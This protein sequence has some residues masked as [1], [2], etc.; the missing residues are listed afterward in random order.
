MSEITDKTKEILPDIIHEIFFAKEKCAVCGN[1]Y[2]SL[3]LEHP[4]F[5]DAHK[6]FVE[7][8]KL[9]QQE[10][11]KNRKSWDQLTDPLERFLSKECPN[12]E[13]AK[14]FVSKWARGIHEL[15]IDK[16][17]LDIPEI[18]KF[19]ATFRAMAYDVS[20]VLEGREER[21]SEMFMSCNYMTTVYGS[22]L[23]H[24]MC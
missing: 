13:A 6:E 8:R 11:E 10:L 24:A 1:K 19:S 17:E 9:E 3:I 20:I 18:G 22:E 15:S 5:D 14:I 21:L 23:Y 2:N 4:K 12:L 7:K 16:Q